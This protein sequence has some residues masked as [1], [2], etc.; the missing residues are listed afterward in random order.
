M[1]ASGVHRSPE[2]GEGGG[3]ADIVGGVEI[4]ENASDRRGER[5]AQEPESRG[6]EAGEVGTGRAASARGIRARQ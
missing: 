4:G 1:T 6:M 5:S 3:E 2:G